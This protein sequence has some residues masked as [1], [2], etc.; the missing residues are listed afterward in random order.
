VDWIVR[1]EARTDDMTDDRVKH[2]ARNGIKVELTDNPAGGQWCEL[3]VTVDATKHDEALKK[4]DLKLP[5]HRSWS[6]PV[7][8]FY[9]VTAER[10]DAP[11]G[12]DLL[13]TAGVANRLGVS[14]ARVR[15]L[16]ER[17]DFPRALSLPGVAEAIYRTADI[18]A[19][20]KTCDWDLK[21]G[22]PRR[23]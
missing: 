7:G 13:S 10:A 23:A 21:A 5:A 14:D 8:E 18:D 6:M 15:Q 17:L 22:R 2:L 4:A 19:W 16:A 9:R 20:A 1:F 3:I 12:H 11:T